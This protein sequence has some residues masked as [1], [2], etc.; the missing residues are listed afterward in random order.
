MKTKISGIYKITNNI[1]GYFYI[2]SSKNIELRWANH[3]CPSTWKIYANNPLYL[4][5]QKY[6]LE[7]FKFEIVEETSQLK[8][9]EQ[10]FIDLL[11]P[12][13]NNYRANG[14]DFERYKKHQKE[15][16][17]STEVKEY[18]Q[19]EKY[20]NIYRKSN[21]KYFNQL[22]LY[23]GKTITLGTLSKRFQRH[24]ILHPTLE[25]KK[26]LLEE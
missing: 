14:R 3:K 12:S 2:G 7:N 8:E 13:Y 26:Y 22:C 15:Y 20:K 11:K 9:R 5:F 24:G 1:T 4:D 10:Y 6:G 18:H 16:L 17:Q 25:A 21:K 19:T 23:E